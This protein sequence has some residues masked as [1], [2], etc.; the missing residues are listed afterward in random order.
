MVDQNRLMEQLKKNEL[1]DGDQLA[2][3]KEQQKMSSSSVDQSVDSGV[4]ELQQKLISQNG[5]PP[6]QAVA[7]ML[8]HLQQIKNLENESDLSQSKADRSE[9]SATDSANEQ[10][11]NESAPHIVVKKK[12]TLM[13]IPK[14]EE[15]P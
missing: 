7:T 14:M 12:S 11:D 8:Q 2:P 13:N 9:L 3:L 10:A 1:V 15:L 4:S 6:S 5:Q